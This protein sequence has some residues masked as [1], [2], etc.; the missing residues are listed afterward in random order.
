[1]C[2]IQMCIELIA[3]QIK[4]RVIDEKIAANIVA[5]AVEILVRLSTVL[6]CSKFAFHPV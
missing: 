6:H 1:M 5:M 4:F 2:I 3:I